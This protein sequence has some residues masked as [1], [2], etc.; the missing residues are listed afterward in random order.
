LL[1]G[2]A[3]AAMSLCAAVAMT[4]GPIAA[5]SALAVGLFNSIMFPTIFSITL[6]RARAPKPATSGL[7]CLAIVGGAA[8][9]YAVGKIADLA[10]LSIAFAAPA[11]AYAAIAAFA[12]MAASSRNRPDIRERPLP[13]R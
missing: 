6:E 9:P 3:T 5:Y 12:G 4:E 10:T 2:A 1:F 8:L 11:L 7:L 13:V